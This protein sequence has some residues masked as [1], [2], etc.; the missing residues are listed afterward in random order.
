MGPLSHASHFVSSFCTGGAKKTE[1]KSQLGS[2]YASKRAAG[3]MKKKDAPEPYAY[4]PLDIK[5][6]NKRC[7]GFRRRPT[8]RRGWNRS[9]PCL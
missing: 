7:V 9:H 3:D 1:S 4:V 2:A 8:R 6:L 5:T